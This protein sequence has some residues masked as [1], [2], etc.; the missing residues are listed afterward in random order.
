MN[1]EL[2][3]TTFAMIFLIMGI[4]IGYSACNIHWQYTITNSISK[5]QIQNIE[6]NIPFNQ[7]QMEDRM[8][9]Y[10]SYEQGNPTFVDQPINARLK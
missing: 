6:V 2:K 3:L 7:T 10:I 4:A 9:N 5:L 1:I 8:I